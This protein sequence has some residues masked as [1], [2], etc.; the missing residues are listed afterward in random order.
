M[1]NVNRMKIVWED[2]LLLAPAIYLFVLP[3]PHTT[4]VRS[5]AFG[6][7]AL[8]L[9]ATWRGTPVPP[10][11]LK[12][13]FA[14]WLALSL[15][16]LI[17]ALHP[18]YSIGEIKSEILQGFLTFLIFF[19]ATRSDRELNFWFFVL[20]ASV[21][22]TG[23]F[24]L[25]DSLRGLDPYSV[26]M[27]GGALYYSGYLNTIF[28]VLAA[29]AILRNAWQRMFLICLM[30]FLLQTAISSTSRAVWLGFILEFTIFGGLYLKNMGVG[31]LTR[32]TVV[33]AGILSLVLF[34][35][36]FLYVAKE[37]RHLT[38][39]PVEIIAQIA[40]ADLRPKLWADSVTFIKERPLTGAGFGRMVLSVELVEQQNDPNH[41]HAHNL[42]LNSALQLGLLGPM[43]LAYFFYSIT[44]ELWQ[45]MKST[46]REL[47]I[48]GIAGL[49]M[50]GGIFGQSM[51]E[52]VFVR[53]LAWLFWA[54]LGMTLGYAIHKRRE[55][56]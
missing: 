16:T 12:P 10:V 6:L 19:R 9:L 13:A 42:I 40:K 26:G 37:K 52:D 41:T 43:L 17:W 50:V 20:I 53:H 24:E 45:L 49:S 51:V 14:G 39:G 7:S 27:H 35:A 31:L 46:D 47:R 18:E 29:V 55:V 48:L 44:R 15:V 54:L 8:L 33:L 30:V 2:L 22:V 5:V 56:V 28:P 23:I 25:V 1:Q 21:L 4:A 36:A 3:L 34:S 38:G 11:P 32:R